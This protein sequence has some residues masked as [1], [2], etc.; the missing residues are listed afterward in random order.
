MSYN[1]RCDIVSFSV[2]EIDNW[3]THMVFKM[4]EVMKYVLQ[5]TYNIVVTYW[6]GMSLTALIYIWLM[7][8]IES[9]SASSHDSL[10]PKLNQDLDEILSGNIC[11]G[12]LNKINCFLQ[13]QPWMSQYEESYSSVSLSVFG[14][15]KYLFCQSSHLLLS[16]HLTH[17]HTGSVPCHQIS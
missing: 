6:T 11:F 16:P 15:L 12:F 10:L 13:Q 1:K 14:N 4:D 2:Y 7:A 17:G 5:L 8:F 3:D 9:N